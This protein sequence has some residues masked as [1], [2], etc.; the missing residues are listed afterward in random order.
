MSDEPVFRT[1]AEEVERLTQEIAQ[2]REIMRDVLNRLSQI[3][4]HAKRAV[5][6]SGK[7]QGARPSKASTYKAS[8][9]SAD[10]IKVFDDLVS[11]W[12]AKGGEPVATR[13]NSF[14]LQDLQILAS[15]IGLPSGKKAPKKRLISS[16]VGR[17][18]ESLML[19][20]N[21]NVTLPRAEQSN[22][23]E[24][25]GNDADTKKRDSDF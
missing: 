11:L 21:R 16:I 20:A 22:S 25:P 10:A 18:N 3:E 24:L 23:S 4:R 8:L 7:P 13:L 12:R 14:A 19:A 1:V 5:G 17:I 15:E 9:K 6:E 2:V